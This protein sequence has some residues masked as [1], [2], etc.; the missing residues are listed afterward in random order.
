MAF[1]TSTICFPFTRSPP[2]FKVPIKDGFRKSPA[3]KSIVFLFSFS[4]SLC[5]VSTLAIPPKA[6]PCIGAIS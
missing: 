3:I 1:I 4:K 5:T 2:T 6:P